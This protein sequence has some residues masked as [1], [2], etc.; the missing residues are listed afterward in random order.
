MNCRSAENLFSAFV[1]DELNQKER[2]FLESHLLSC[3]RCTASMRELKAS[4]DLCG[5]LPDVDTSPH[6]E[7][8]VMAMIRSGEALRP[9]LIEWLR[10]LVTI[11]RIRPFALA[12]AGAS[13]VLIGSFA[14]NALHLNPSAVVADRTAKVHETQAAAPSGVATPEEVAATT[15]PEPTAPAPSAPAAVKSDAGYAWADH[16]VRTST[17]IPDTTVPNP[18]A[19][20]EDEYITDQFF[21]ERGTDGGNNP[22]ITPVSSRASDDVYITF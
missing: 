17:S 4:M 9:S 14:M 13:A 21:L 1:E 12:G 10:G 3:R 16:S 18:G 5:A 15:T 2:R 11:E 22:T 20:Y 19:R 6:F 7:D 8:D